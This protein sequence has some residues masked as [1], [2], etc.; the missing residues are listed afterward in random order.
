MLLQLRGSSGSGKSYVAHQ[1]LERYEHKPLYNPAVRKTV[2]YAY[3]LPGGLF[4][5]GG[6]TARGGGV[7]GW[8]VETTVR[9][10]EALDEPGRFIFFEGLLISRS[11][12]QWERLARNGHEYVAAILDTPPELCIQRVYERNGGKQINEWRLRDNHRG[13]RTAV[14]YMGEAGIDTV[15]IRHGRSVEDVLSVLRDH[16]WT[17]DRS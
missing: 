2:P 17:G 16:G 5:L 3:A 8:P 15:T 6:Y 7:D 1:L 10:L 14:R 12:G 4:I 13:A 9:E 11:R